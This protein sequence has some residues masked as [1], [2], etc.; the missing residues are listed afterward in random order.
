MNVLESI[1]LTN[2]KMYNV[3]CNKCGVGYDFIGYSKEEINRVV[4]QF[5]EKHKDCKI[6]Y[7]P[8]GGHN[9]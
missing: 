2:K 9:V 3:R 1:K 5:A 8:K 6:T 4:D 7:K